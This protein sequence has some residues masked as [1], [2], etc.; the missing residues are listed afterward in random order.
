MNNKLSFVEPGNLF[1]VALNEA[2]EICKEDEDFV[3][4]LVKMD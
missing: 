4:V 3:K 2:K 1:N